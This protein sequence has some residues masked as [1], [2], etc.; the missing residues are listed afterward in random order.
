M[1]SRVDLDLAKTLHRLAPELVKPFGEA[2]RKLAIPNE[3]RRESAFLDEWMVERQHHGVVVDDVKRMAQ[4]SGVP[5]AS[6]LPEV[7]AMRLQELHELTRAL[8]GKAEDDSVLHAML[9]RRSW[10]SASGSGTRL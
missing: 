6:H 8:V 9:C 3:Q 10:R 7:M 2:V 5:D 4:L 1:A